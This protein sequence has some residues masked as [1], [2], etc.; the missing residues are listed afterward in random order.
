[1]TEAFN[2][3]VWKEKEKALEPLIFELSKPG[4]VGY[5]PPKPCEKVKEEVGDVLKTIPE[6]IRRKTPIGLPEVSEPQLMRHYLHLAQMNYAIDLGFYPLGSCTM[7]YNPKINEE[8]A[9]MDKISRLHP[10]QDVSTVQGALKLLY[11]L[12]KMLAEISGMSR[13][14]LQPSAGAH[15]EFTGLCIIRKYHEER[16]QLRSK[17]E[18]IVPDSAHGTNP[19]SASMAGFDVVTIPSSTDGCV[20]LEALRAAVGEQTAG[21]MLT[22]PNTLGVFE[23]NILTIADIIHDAGGLLYYDGANL[24]GVL[25]KVRPGDMGFDIVHFNLHKTFSTPHG[26]GG[27]G[28]GPVGVKDNLVPYL[29]VPTVEYDEKRGL[30][31]LDY[32]RPK[33][34]GKVKGFFGNFGVLVKA[35][36]YILSLGADGLNEVAEVAVLNAN[37]LAKKIKEIHGFSLPY[38]P[39]KPRKHECVISATQLKSET[40]VTALN[41]AKRILDFGI[42]APVI[43]FPQ[44]VEEALMIE[45]TE[46]ETKETLDRFISVMRRI[47]SEAYNS[48]EKVLNAPHHTSVGKVD[49]VKAARKPILS[50]KM[51]QKEL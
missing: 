39:D 50:W 32:N 19:A 34:V 16:G 2:Q 40:G 21:L 43:Y 8:I 29:P 13:V 18:I 48:P 25:N 5:L 49:E 30:Y 37:Y 47:S 44:I 38:A 26:G 46:T 22:N 20:D 17:R 27:P 28:A 42:H 7:K 12:E 51:Y 24:N 31:Y 3:A 14:S 9:K 45:P 35:Y 41:V 11:H 6:K 33:T 36:S 23:E 4:R 15:G 1:M 10:Y